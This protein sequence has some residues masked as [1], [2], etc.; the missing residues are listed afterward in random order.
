MSITL[1]SDLFKEKIYYG[2]VIYFSLIFGSFFVLDT[3]L[4][5]NL[6]YV[7]VPA[8]L[9]FSYKNRTILDWNIVAKPL[10]YSIILLIA[11]NFASIFWSDPH[12][13]EKLIQRGKMIVLFPLILTPF[14][15][16]IAYKPKIWNYC[17]TSFISLAIVS[18]PIVFYINFIA[19]SG[20]F[21]RFE[22]IGKATNPVQC[23]LL[24]GLAFMLLVFCKKQLPLYKNMSN[25]IIIILSFFLG[26]VVF[27]TMSRGPFLA[28][29]VTAGFI[30]LLKLDIK[31]V[32]NIKGIFILFA[33]ILLCA[34]AF[35]IFSNA[36]GFYRGF[37]GRIDI[38]ERAIE[39]I[40]Q[41]PIFGYGLATKFS[42][43]FTYNE[44][45][46]FIGHAH[47]LYLSALVH[48]GVI[49]LLI[50][51]CAMGTAL[52]YATL[53]LRSI[54]A[55]CFIFLMSGTILGLTDFGGYYTNLGTTWIVFW[56]PI[57]FLIY[58]NTHQLD[59]LK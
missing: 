29:I 57:A 32:M 46:H 8:L 48:T 23:S 34:I 45:T 35:A 42:Y 36:A 21:E 44:S 50:L 51:F 28:F 56:F 52:Y 43:P 58:R 38:W 20:S 10:L 31:K 12:D 4:Q 11:F 22:G 13:T 7:G 49:G 59:A 27:L 19:T 15:M 53:R 33:A 47:N 37:S 1:P 24:Y 26:L 18:L 17:L 54:S 6:M 5:R 14:I 9:F 30:F 55:D 3:N 16:A 39:L 25:P 2:L 40:Q 41:K